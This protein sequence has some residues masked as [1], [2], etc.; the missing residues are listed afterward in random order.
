MDI[1]VKDKTNDHKFTICQKK[2]RK[3]EGKHFK[4]A[5]YFVKNQI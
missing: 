4:Q 3:K 2:K 1:L 5:K